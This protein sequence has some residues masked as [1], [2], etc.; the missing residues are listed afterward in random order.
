[1][2]P[3]IGKEKEVL[4]LR[5]ASMASMS[6]GIGLTHIRKC[7]FVQPGFFYSGFYSYTTGIER[8]MKLIVI[9]NYRVQN[10]DRFP[11][12]KQLKAFGH[13]LTDLF[14]YSL[15]IQKELDLSIDAKRFY[16]DPLYEKIIEFLSDFAT[17]SRYYNLDILTGGNQNTLEPYHRWNTEISSTIIQRHYRKNNDV[18]KAK[19]DIAEKVDVDTF[20]L[21][22]DEDGNEIKDL[23]T[24][25]ATGDS[26][27]TKQR[28]SMFYLYEISRFLNEILRDL[29]YKGNLYPIL[30]EFFA[31][32][33]ND[34][35]TDVLNKKSWNPNPPYRF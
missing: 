32:F 20:T 28:Y 17:Q 18:F 19:M 7:D 26:I 10:S 23:K 4:L 21:M 3:Q 8:L 14:Q 24:F 34:N 27:P 13:N 1:M 15:K 22:H 5:E 11:N 25:F 33:R 35:K 30:P 31:I 12:N 29:H 2:R 6:I 9:C 16:D